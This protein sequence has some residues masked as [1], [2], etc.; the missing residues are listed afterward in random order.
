MSQ[1]AMR[2]SRSLALLA[3]AALALGGYGAA[4][5]APKAAGPGAT[6]KTFLDSFN[7]GD[8]AAAEATHVAEPTIIDEVA[9]HHW[10]GAGA[11]KAWADDL[12]K[13]SDAAGQTDGKVTITGTDRTV[14]DG[15]NA[16]VVDRVVYTYK[17]HKKKM[18]EPAHMAVSLHQ[19]AGAW[20]ITGWAWAGTT[21]HAVAPKP[22]PAAAAPG[23]AAGAA[24][25]PP[26]K[27]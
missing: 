20:K 11:F 25:T 26:P 21:P 3:G 15:D 22:A 7:K 17:E 27:P 16:Y 13:V 2:S 1:F 14:V 24:P 19:D 10:Q 12:K 8:V 6:V 18:E 4:Q 9:P 23:A 5:A